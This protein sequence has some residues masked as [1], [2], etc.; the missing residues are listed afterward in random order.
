MLY[1][2]AKLLELDREGIDPKDPKD[3]YETMI[4]DYK[5]KISEYR[6]RFGRY[7]TLKDKK[8]PKLNYNPDTKK[9]ILEPVPNVAV[10]LRISVAGK[11]GREEWVYSEVAVPIKDGIVQL[12]QNSKIVYYGEW[13]I[14]MDTNPDLAY[15]MLDKH[16]MIKRGQY[17]IEDPISDERK[18]AEDR[19]NEAKLD[20]IVYGENAKLNIDLAYLRLIA[21]RWGIA[22]ADKQNKDQLQNALYDKVKTEE[23]KKRRNKTGRGID[24]F[25][26]DVR[27]SDESEQLQVAGHVRDAI[28]KNIL[29]FDVGDKTWKINYGDGTYY[30]VFTVAVSDLQNK[31]EAIILYL[32]QDNHIYSKL[33]SAMG[34]DK[35]DVG[36][37]ID[38]M[39]V[40]E[41]NDYNALRGYAKSLDIQA[42]QKTKEELR[43]AIMTKLQE[44][45][46]I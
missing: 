23:A 28:D 18:K 41:T 31:D 42:F 8:E 35:K 40:R 20:N 1:L 25:V 2:N 17:K 30:N 38:P 13:V 26:N 43:A 6:Q 14:D 33:I 12:E 37:V 24:E 22:A 7:L 39:I 16:S 9:S 32:Q 3:I 4:L 45:G 44:M 19:R 21:K 36:D 11:N 34:T 15:F 27:A 29:V 46:K 5:K 10:P